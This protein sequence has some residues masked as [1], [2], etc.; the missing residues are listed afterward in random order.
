MHFELT[1]Q[2]WNFGVTSYRFAGHSIGLVSRYRVDV[3]MKMLQGRDR[4]D[5]VVITLLVEYSVV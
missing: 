4:V 1:E 5:D 3:E 2:L